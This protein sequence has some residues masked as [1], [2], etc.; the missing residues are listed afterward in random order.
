[1]AA[2]IL[3]IPPELRLMIYNR[4][5]LSTD[6]SINNNKL[7]RIVIEDVPPHDYEARMATGFRGYQTTYQLKHHQEDPCP[8]KCSPNGT[9]SF[10]SPAVTTCYMYN[11]R[12]VSVNLL[13]AS[14][15]IWD[16]ASHFLYSRNTFHFRSMSAVIP[17]LNNRRRFWPSFNSLSFYLS[18][19]WHG[20]A[21]ET[22]QDWT[23]IFHHIAN[24]PD[25]NPG[26]LAIFVLDFY[27]ISEH[28]AISDRRL[29]HWAYNL[30]EVRGLEFLKVDFFIGRR[31]RPE[32]ALELW[33]FLA[34]TMLRPGR[35]GIANVIVAV[36][37]QMEPR[38]FQD[39]GGLFFI[40][41]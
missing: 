27:G 23:R 10:T 35:V 7:P 24:A 16:E 1:M 40:M 20:H 15:T 39:T 30:R 18:L 36:S 28:L 32:N 33:C 4:T 3:T 5:L 22:H 31:S 17:F 38:L 12:D 2:S 34:P 14:R 19:D 6:Y 26:Y 41:S 13:H 29:M 37:R 25:L 9:C 8:Q 11:S 21:S